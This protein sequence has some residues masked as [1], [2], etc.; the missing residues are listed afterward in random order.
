MYRVYR[1][2]EAIVA[3]LRSAES[4]YMEHATSCTTHEQ[5]PLAFCPNRPN[6]KFLGPLTCTLRTTLA[7]AQ[8]DRVGQP[9]AG[10]GHGEEYSHWA[11]LRRERSQQ[12]QPNIDIA[13]L[14]GAGGRRMGMRGVSR[15]LPFAA[16]VLPAAG[17]RSPAQA[18]V[19]EPDDL[20]D[21]SYT[22]SWMVK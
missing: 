7:P 4:G 20:V 14:R 10:E 21:S 18:V 2:C 13:A 3:G 15:I 19:G 1:G 22:V 11:R 12:R 6:P 9:K 17:V 16:L 8:A 5:P